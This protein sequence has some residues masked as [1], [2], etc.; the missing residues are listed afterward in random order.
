MKA[1]GKFVLF[2]LAITVATQGLDC[3]C[4]DVPPPAAPVQFTCDQ[5][6]FWAKCNETWMQ[7]YCKCSCGTCDEAPQLEDVP[8]DLETPEIIDVAVETEVLPGE[9]TEPGVCA[10]KDE[11]RNCKFSR[12]RCCASCASEA[13]VDF[14]C[15]QIGN[16]F[17]SSCSCAGGRG[18]A[19]GSASSTASISS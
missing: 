15:N 7:G 2:V 16:S 19:R 1:V 8:E 18:R 4:E 5:Q 11:P 6:E 9:P 14:E 10:E 13:E 17:A 3:A 12:E